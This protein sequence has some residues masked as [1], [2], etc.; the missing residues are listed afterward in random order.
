MHVSY[1]KGFEVFQT[2]NSMRVN[3]EHIQDVS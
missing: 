3:Q 1:Q 2:Q